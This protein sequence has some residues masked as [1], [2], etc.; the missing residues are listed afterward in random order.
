MGRA[1][2]L[3]R[4]IADKLD[5]KTDKGLAPVDGNRGWYP[6]IREFATGA[7][8]ANV[9]VTLEDSLQYWAVFRCVSLISGDFAKCRP[10]LMQRDG[11][12][13]WKEIERD[14][15]S[16]VLAKPN[17]MQTRI[18]FFQDWSNSKLTRGNA[19][20]LKQRDNRGRVV[21][22]Y[23]LD[24]GRVRPMVA[25]DGAVFY[26]LKR[27]NVT[28][29]EG[30]RVLAPASEIIHDRWNCLYHPLVGLSPLYAA[31]INALTALRAETNSARLFGNSGKPGGILSTE[32]EIKQATAER[33]KSYW[34]EN[35]TGENA[36]KVAVLG[37]GLKYQSVAMTAVEAELINTLKWNDAAI[38]GAFGIPSYMINAG[39]APAYNNVEALS[40]QYYSQCLQVHFEAAELLLDEGLGLDEMTGATLGVEFDLEDLLRMDTPTKV[41]TVGE[42]IKAGF[43]APNEARAKFDLPPVKGGDTPYLQQQNY[44]LEALGK[45]DEAAPA[46]SEAAKPAPAADD[47]PAEDEGE[48]IDEERG[49]DSARQAWSGSNARH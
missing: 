15:V 47:E 17:P 23:V 34:D 37:S 8:Q 41:K 33:I 46:P 4:S 11:K 42:A 16:P 26:E 39:T 40:Q 36:G 21:R 2:K 22:L 35:F 28:S 48:E 3:L 31:G 5:P 18:Q 6:I 13:I 45:R 27:D 14:D 9:T 29:V 25:D 1:A 7:W 12:G 10:K 44:S 30:D 32:S 19:Y 38:A 49:L 20:V 24:P 43:M